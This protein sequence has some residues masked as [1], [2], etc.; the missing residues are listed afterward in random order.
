[1]SLNID[2]IQ[3]QQKNQNNAASEKILPIPGHIS[4]DGKYMP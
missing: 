2:L 1:M 4:R 3:K